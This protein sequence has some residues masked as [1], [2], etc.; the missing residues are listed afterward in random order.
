MSK[1]YK[2][3]PAIGVAR[4]GNSPDE[5]YLALE[6]VGGRPIACDASGNALQDNG[7]VKFVEQY[8]DS[9]GRVKRQAAKIWLTVLGCTTWL[10]MSRSGA[11]TA[12]TQTTT[13]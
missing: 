1:S 9:L 10:A 3:H 8:K 11:M 7:K 2:I 5:F 12:T 6:T 4:L 13:K